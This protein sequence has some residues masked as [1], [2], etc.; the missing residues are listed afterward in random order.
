MGFGSMEFF[1][2]WLITG[3]YGS[4]SKICVAEPKP[5]GAKVFQLEPEPIKN[6]IW[7]WNGT[8]NLGRLRL[9]CLASEKRNDLKMLTLFFLLFSFLRLHRR[10]IEASLCLNKLL[11][12]VFR[13]RSWSEPRCYRWSRSQKKIWCQ[14]Q[15]K[16]ARLHNTG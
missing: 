16:M 7:S 8:D 9:L 5:I 10:F 12:S 4:N 14:S 15:G 13:S 11:P 1:Y 2:I 6:F 3:R